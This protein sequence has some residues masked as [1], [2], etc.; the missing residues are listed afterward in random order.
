ME[1]L[2]IAAIILVGSIFESFLCVVLG[3]NAQTDRT[4][5]PIDEVTELRYSRLGSE[6]ET[7]GD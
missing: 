3:R 1:L 4:D 6:Y 2:S 5:A 7:I